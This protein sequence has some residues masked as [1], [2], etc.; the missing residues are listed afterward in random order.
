MSITA[1]KNPHGPAPKP[2]APVPRSG[3]SEHWLLKGFDAI[4]RFLASLKLAVIGL[5][6]LAAVLAY[7][8][9]YEKAHGTGAVQDVVYRS[10][11]FAILLAFIGTNVLCAALIR[12]PWS[13]RQTGFVITHAGILVVLVG[14]WLSIQYCSEG[15]IGVLEGQQ[16]NQIV[17][18]KEAA[19]RVQRLD[20]ES[21]RP[22]SE[23]QY[24]F[25]PG[26]F[27]WEASKVAEGALHVTPSVRSTV[28]GIGLAATAAWV[29][30]TIIWALGRIPRL[31]R[32]L[33]WSIFG[34][35]A[36]TAMLGVGSA[37]GMQ[38]AREERITEPGD[39]LKIV[40]KDFMPAS[41]P[42]HLA[43]VEGPNGVPMIRPSLYLKPPRAPQE[44]DV[45]GRMDEGDGRVRWLKA[46]DP[47]VGRDTRDL[48]P[49]LLS[50][51]YAPNA[52]YVADFLALPSDPLKDERIRIHYKTK[53]GVDRVFEWPNATPDQTAV[54]LPESDLSLKRQHLDEKGLVEIL[55][56]EASPSARSVLKAATQ[57]IID[58]H[59]DFLMFELTE[60]SGTPS[61][62]VVA[63][64]LP[65]VPSLANP[66]AKLPI[67]VSY[68]RPPDLG[69]IAMEGRSGV[70]DL[71]ATPDGKVYYRA[72]GRDGVRGE[73][74][75][76]PLKRRVQLVGG[77]NQPVTFSIR[78]DDYLTS[79][80]EKET[81]TPIDLPPN[82][83]DSGY[84]ACLVE[85]TANGETKEFWLR[86]K[87]Q[88]NDPML[89]E[90]RT[91]QIGGES[92]RIAFDNVR[93]EVPFHIKLT[94]FEVEFDPGTQQPSAYTS[95]IL[96]SDPA[97][98]VE[99]KPATI[100]MNEPFVW[101]GYTIY[102]ASYR[103]MVIPHTRTTTGQFAS[104]FQVRYDPV[105]GVTYAGCL[106]VVI[107]IFTQFY[108]RAGVFSSRSK[109][110]VESV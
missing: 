81:V 37:A 60:G 59:P 101:K 95:E 46:A 33:G 49:L 28:L 103:P 63:S 42:I 20:S 83:I 109:S 40:V 3:T 45:F 15:Q 100:T 12:F 48:G 4:Y 93:T 87:E 77:P 73:P 18:D 26:S 72:F 92:L 11:F 66:E 47:I 51:Q 98:K 27:A 85:M 36:C 56:T 8:T 97:R 106:L 50:F 34:G 23:Y 35:L 79:G 54:T 88:D 75:L 84:A 64:N 78:I 21:G 91:M 99:E 68:Y 6:T 29:G 61:R 5:G 74:G 110:A 65:T 108:M 102:Q 52:G 38:V 9:F 10:P 7:S 89:P 107:G 24:P 2:A 90:F 32:A 53:G 57:A 1:R 82:Q 71:M 41:T 14:S 62:I 67:R 86:R 94:D 30:F 31:P 22:T 58:E 16:S 43:P 44:I 96:F 25:F 104:I 13:K 39:P 17:H 76:L 105:W 80:V 55:S 19:V 70:V 69:K